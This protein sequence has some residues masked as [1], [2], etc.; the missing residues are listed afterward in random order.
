MPQYWKKF[1]SMAEIHF[2]INQKKY[3]LFF[4]HKL[5]SQM[6]WWPGRQNELSFIQLHISQFIRKIGW[7]NSRLHEFRHVVQIDKINEN[8]P[9][10]IKLI[11]G[12]QGTALVFGVHLPWWFIEGDAVVTETAL[13]KFGRGRFPSFLME[14]Q[15]QVVEKGVF[16]YDKAYFGSYRDFVPNHYKLGYYLVGGSR[17][18]FGSESGIRFCWL[19]LVK[20]R[21]QFSPL[22]NVLKSKTGYRQR[23]HCINLFSTAFSRFGWKKTGITIHCR[24]K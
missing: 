17:A 9:E 23:L 2:I 12:Q 22:N 4:I 15:A 3:L 8:L 13:S 20:N 1:I 14:H 5:F 11:L 19:V 6:D 24:S 21:F 7:N 16:S 18:I 10:L